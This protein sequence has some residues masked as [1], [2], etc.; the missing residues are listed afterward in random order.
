V[1]T[2]S[3]ATAEIARIVPRKSRCQ[4]L[5]SLGYISVTHSESLASVNLTQ[6]AAN[7]AILS[8]KHVMTAI[9][10]FKVTQGHQF[11][12]R[13]KAQLAN[14]TNTYEEKRLEAFEMK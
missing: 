12:Y 14:N 5:G 9:E 4:K 1:G 7:A 2:R 8:E 10:M 3:S 11:W 6:F 13:S